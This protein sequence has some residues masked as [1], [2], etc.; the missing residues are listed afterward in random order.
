MSD[1]SLRALRPEDAGAARALV[2]AQLGGSLYASRVFEQLDVAL[3]NAD[4]ECLS[5]AAFD[6][7][8]VV[9]F[10]LY[11]A[12]AG[13]A[14]VVKLHALIGSERSAL[15]AVVRAITAAGDW[16]LAVCETPDD[17]AFHAGGEALREF[18]FEVEGRIQDLVRDGVDLLIL[19][20]RAVMK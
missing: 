20:W 2:S 5:L 3:G 18:G 7:G 14:G 17:T 6:G 9:G 19:A 8:D 16:R 11:G 1:A 15:S 10:T 12:I 4:P 13:A